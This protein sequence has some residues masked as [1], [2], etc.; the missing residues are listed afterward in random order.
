MTAPTFP[1]SHTLTVINWRGYEREVLCEGRFSFDGE[2]LEVQT[3]PGIDELSDAD[4][5][6]LEEGLY[7]EAIDAHAE[8]QQEQADHYGEARAA[9]SYIPAG[10]A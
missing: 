8:W 6:C 2:T 7:P 3:F 4:I 1:F 5:E 10:A 9:E